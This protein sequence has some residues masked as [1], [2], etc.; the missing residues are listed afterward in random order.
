MREVGLIVWVVLLVVGVTSSIVSSIRKAST[1]GQQRP[2]ASPVTPPPRQSTVKELV[3]AL[4]A[5]AQAQAQA[6][7]PPPRPA[8]APRVTPPSKPPAARAAPPDLLPWPT[9]PAQRS[10]AHRLF[11]G[12]GDAVRGIIAA[13]ILGSPRGLRDEPFR[14]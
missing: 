5:Q 4:Q 12:R 2:G 7:Q 14:R 6:A 9:A 8:P 3:A 10:S 11:A 1:A 13:E